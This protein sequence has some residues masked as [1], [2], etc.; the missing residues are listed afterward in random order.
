MTIS[1]D[2][3]RLDFINPDRKA[4]RGRECQTMI[5]CWWIYVEGRGVA[6]YSRH[7]PQCNPVK[8]VAEKLRDKLYPWAEVRFFQSVIVSYGNQK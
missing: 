7:F 8:E 2:D 5:G 3:P 4:P 1:I 6:I